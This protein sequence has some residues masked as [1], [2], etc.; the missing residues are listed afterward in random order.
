M[1]DAI[2]WHPLG[3]PGPFYVGAQN[4]ALYI[5][6]GRAPSM[7]NDYPW[8]E[9]PRVA[10]ARVFEPSEG[11]CLPINASANARAIAEVPAMVVALRGIVAADG[12]TDLQAFTQARAILSRIDG[13]AA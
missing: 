11:D 2:N 1:T 13:G 7:N 10:V 5:I 9:A 8:H 3:T 12:L 6:A 4:D